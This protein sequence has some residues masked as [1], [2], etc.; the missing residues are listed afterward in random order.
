MSRPWARSGARAA[1]ALGQAHLRGHVIER[2]AHDAT[3]VLVAVRRLD[4]QGL[5]LLG[6]EK[7]VEHGALKGGAES[8]GA[9]HD[10]IQPRAPVVV[11]L[12]PMGHRRAAVGVAETAVLAVDDRDERGGDAGRVISDAA[13][14]ARHVR[15]EERRPHGGAD[16]CDASLAIVLVLGCDGRADLSIAHTRIGAEMGAITT[17]FIRVRCGWSSRVSSGR[18]G[19]VQTRVAQRANA[20]RACQ[21][22]FHITRGAAEDRCEAKSKSRQ[23]RSAQQP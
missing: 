15:Q 20:P 13:R 6:Q 8:Q 12:R 10:Q 21:T 1:R 9:V 3:K 23:A 5:V 17:N 2:L 22:R 4:P 7:D 16:G 11:E 18:Y 19:A 14:A